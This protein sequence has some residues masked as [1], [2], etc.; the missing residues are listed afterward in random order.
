MVIELL[1]ETDDNHR[2][3]D[4]LV[5]AVL[6]VIE[7]TT[8]MT[9]GETGIAVGSLHPELHK[10]SSSHTKGIHQIRNKNRGLLI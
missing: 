9:G 7:E 5:V 4:Q 2:V 1:Q 10:E 8:I 3:D 6:V